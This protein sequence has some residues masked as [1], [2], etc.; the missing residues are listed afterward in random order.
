MS[1]L[2]SSFRRAAKAVFPGK[3]QRPKFRA[4]PRLE[5]LERRDL[6]TAYVVTSALDVL[7]DTTPGEVTL[8]DA[9]TAINTQAA[10]GN[11]V[12]G[13]AT[14][15]ITFAIGAPGSSATINV[16]SSGIAAGLPALSRQVTING[17]SQGGTGY[18]GPPLIVLNGANAG[19]SSGLELDAGS[20][21]STIK[22]LMIQQFAENGI[23]LNGVSACAITG[24][25]IGIASDGSMA[26]GN[27]NDGIFVHN[28]ASGNSI[29]GTSAADGNTISGNGNAGIEL[30]GSMGNTIQGN[31]IGLTAAGTAS[32]ANAGDGI[33]LSGAASSNLIGGSAAGT[34]NVISGN[35]LHGIEINGPTSLRNSILGNR[36]GT[37]AAGATAL[38]NDVD[39]ILLSGGTG[40]NL[41]GGAASGA[42]NLISANNGNGIELVGS[43]GN[44]LLG[45]RIGTNAAGTAALGNLLDGVS[46]SS[47]ANNSIGGSAAGNLISGNMLHGIAISGALSSGNRLQGNQIGVS[48]NGAGALGNAV[49][50]VLID[51]QAHD[52]AVGGAAPGQGNLISGN[53]RVGVEITTALKNT[54]YGNFIGT[55]RTGTAAIG[56]GGDGVLLAFGASSNQIGGAA[57]GQGNLISGNGNAGVEINASSHNFVQGNRLGTNKAGTGRLGNS[58]DGVSVLTGGQF[59]LIGGPTPGARN[60][61]SGNGVGVDISGVNSSHN[62]VVGNY[63][64]TDITGTARLGNTDFGVSISFAASDNSIGGT[65]SAARN[66]ISGN[67]QAGVSIALANTIH[68]VVAGNFIG[69]DKSGAANLNNGQY[70]VWI[71]SGAS[72]NTVGGLVAAAGNTIAFGTYGVAVTANASVGNAVLGNRIFG[73]SASGIDLGADGITANGANPRTFPNH[74]QNTPVLTTITASSAAGTLTSSPS[75]QFRLEFF[76]S[77]AAGIFGQG[78]IFLGSLTVKTDA[79]GMAGF[80]AH[81]AAVPIGSVVTATATNLTTLDTS[82]FSPPRTRLLIPSAPSVATSTSAQNV[83]LSAQLFDG[84][85]ALAGEKVTFTVAGL[86]GKVVGTVGSGGTVTVQF[87]LPA[88]V[89]RGSYRITASYA[90]SASHPAAQGIGTL[91]VT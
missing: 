33:W 50:G 6:P 91:K 32:L 11:A 3:P 49:D 76:A 90:G 37:D 65:T 87:P 57:A 28:G 1:L 62:S 66:L 7:G 64:G 22:G 30:N 17:F 59:N 24:N 40:G 12:A 52:N 83:A 82:E 81:F 42:G 21:H 51:T 27:D 75:T 34:G 70:G 71:D 5:W 25:Q 77:P 44:T 84:S 73:Q 53:S 89:A 56:N 55:D 58:T 13:T 2:V 31:R 39:G 38:G 61:I 69:T 60:L 43:S 16:G 8:R 47:S 85:T 74:G 80:T 78:K 72:S 35:G 68:N 45:N 63:I 86:P 48:A 19:S 67:G 36:I 79:A 88:R 41:I 18:S 23:D 29:G 10:S 4:R 20:S 26:A 54:V 46:L 14:N 9:L 15:S